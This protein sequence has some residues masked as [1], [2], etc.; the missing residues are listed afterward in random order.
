M[1]FSAT[2]TNFGLYL[3]SQKHT[4]TNRGHNPVWNATQRHLLFQPLILALW[5]VYFYRGAKKRGGGQEGK[6]RAASA[7][8]GLYLGSDPLSHSLDGLSVTVK[9]SVYLPTLTT[10]RKALWCVGLGKSRHFHTHTKLLFVGHIS[11]HT[12]WSNNFMHLLLSWTVN[13]LVALLMS[14]FQ[15]MIYLGLLINFVH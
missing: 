10:W 3:N 4:S 7:L 1:T 15:S 5:P 14:D 9:A 2:H 12:Q 8:R 13:L 6:G 11:N